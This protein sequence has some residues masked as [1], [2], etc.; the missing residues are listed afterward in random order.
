MEEE[1]KNYFS[2]SY[3][4]LIHNV[5]WPTLNEIAETAVLVLFASLI[6]ALVVFVMDFG[7]EHLLKLIYS[8]LTGM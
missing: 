2:A 6:I 8:T 3:D 7:I 4:E 1:K 5:T